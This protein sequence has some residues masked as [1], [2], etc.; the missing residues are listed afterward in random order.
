MYESHTFTVTRV[1][2][3]AGTHARAVK[4]SGPV[5]TL[6]QLHAFRHTQARTREQP[7]TVKESGPLLVTLGR[8]V[9]HKFRHT[10]ARLF[11]LNFTH[12]SKSQ[13]RY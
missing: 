13:V 11:S 7:Y 1:Q 3:H 8:T 10:Q 4:E 5:V 2:T 6:A 9:S 12:D